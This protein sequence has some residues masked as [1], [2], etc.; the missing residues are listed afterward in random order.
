MRSNFNSSKNWSMNK[1]EIFFAVGPSQ[2]LGDLGGLNRE[3]T[4]KSIVDLDWS[5]TRIGGGLGYRFRFHPRWATS[6]QLYFA[7]VNGADSNT[8][9]IIRR[10]RN[11]SFRSPILELSQ[12][13]EFI[14]LANEK[15]GARYGLGKGMR[16]K[17]DMLYIFTGISGFYYNPQTKINGSWT[18]LRPLKT[19]GQ[20][21][22][23]GADEYG[24]LSL[25]IPF[26]I[27]FKI[28]IGEFWRIGM[29]VSYNKT[30][31]DYIDDVST[32]YYDPAI[33]ASEVGQ[34]AVYAA[35]PAI[36]NHSWFTE[37][38]QRGNDQDKDAY[39]FANIVLTRNITYPKPKRGRR[40]KWR[41]RTKF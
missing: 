39:L 2:F 13:I 17:A 36:E 11:L 41:G 40:V 35:N 32:E 27:G 28:A 5:S 29:E 12:R 3:G 26:G 25:A 20:G 31:T 30:F 9:E 22:P 10:S 23:N 37:G 16:T 34:D 24:N 6:T 21:L 4:Q 38:M 18:N 1:H 14:I 19:E 15:R 33:L 7:L 8:D